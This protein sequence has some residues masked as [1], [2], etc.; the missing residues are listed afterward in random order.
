MTERQRTRKVVKLAITLT[1][2]GDYFEADEC[3]GVAENW[4]DSG[5]DDRDDLRGWAI[6]HVSTTESPSEED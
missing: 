4:I 2:E 1:F 6:E 5:L 3:A